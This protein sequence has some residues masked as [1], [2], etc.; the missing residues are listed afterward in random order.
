M[1]K[2]ILLSGVVVVI[3]MFSSSFVWGQEEIIFSVQDPVADDFGPGS[4]NYPTADIFKSMEGLFD[5]TSFK[6]AEDNQN[7]IFIFEFKKLTDPWQ[8]KFGFSLPLIELY[9]DNEKGG[10]TELFRKGANI[11]LNSNHPWNKLL[12]ISGWWVRLYRPEDKG[13]EA[14]NFS[15]ASQSPWDIKNCEV[16][17]TGEKIKLKIPQ[18]KIGSLSNTWIYVL[19]GSFDPFGLDHFRGVKKSLSTWYFAD[20]S[21]NNLKYVPRVIDVVL[22]DGQKQKKVLSNYD[23]NYPVLKPIKITGFSNSRNLIL[24]IFFSI[25]GFVLI[26]YII[27]KF[28]KSGGITQ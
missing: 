17:V 22:P 4:Y 7:Y 14:T 3:V 8:S 10:S 6:I 1:K 20:F 24:S 25:I 26:I 16:K 9:I 13:K 12:K 15:K 28:N 21:D 5:I 23:D 27:I 19:V 11:N 18:E 2:L